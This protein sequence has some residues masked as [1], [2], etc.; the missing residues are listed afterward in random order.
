MNK[1]VYIALVEVGDEPYLVQ[2]EE[3]IPERGYIAFYDG[4]APLLGR[5]VRVDLIAPESET[6]NMLNDLRPIFTADEA[7]GSLWR[8]KENDNDLQ[9]E[10]DAG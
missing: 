3:P 5:I 6:F 9:A 1:F 8:R 4:S 2:S 10:N 7:F